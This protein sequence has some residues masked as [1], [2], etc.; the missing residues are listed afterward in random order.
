MSI[1]H[2]AALGLVAL[3]AFKLG[4]AKASNAAGSQQANAPDVQ[5]EWW[6]YAGTWRG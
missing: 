6:T 3:I 5:A 4:A 2:I 1:E